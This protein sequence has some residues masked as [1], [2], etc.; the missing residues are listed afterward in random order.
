ME[1]FSQA[2][3]Y[4]DTSNSCELKMK[5]FPKLGSIVKKEI[6][7]MIVEIKL[8]GPAKARSW[9]MQ[10]QRN[11]INEIKRLS[12]LR[13]QHNKDNA[14]EFWDDDFSTPEAALDH[15]A[16]AKDIVKE[17]VSK[18]SG[19]RLGEIDISLE[20]DP[21]IL[22]DILEQYGLLDALVPLAV[23][24]QTPRADQLLS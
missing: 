1:E 19:T 5:Q 10:S 24:A 16:L 2:A 7:G 18:I 22:T 15:A 6:D 14:P 3:L 13:K 9:A 21:V 12:E 23:D 11:K 17:S 8:L 4:R 20:S